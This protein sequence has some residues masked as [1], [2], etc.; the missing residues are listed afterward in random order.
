MKN[1]CVNSRVSILSVCCFCFFFFF[2]SLGTPCFNL[3]TNGRVELK[4]ASFKK[5]I[6]I[7]LTEVIS[8]HERKFCHTWTRLL[9]KLQLT[10]SSVYTLTI[11]ALTESTM[12][13]NICI[14]GH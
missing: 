3:Y 6:Y 4:H 14:I 1:D 9:E 5:N 11:K 7:R 12:K 2:F 8:I 10:V 13:S